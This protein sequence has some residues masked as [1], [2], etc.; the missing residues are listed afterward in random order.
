M[1]LSDCARCPGCTLYP[2]CLLPEETAAEDGVGT[3]Q[4]ICLPDP[5]ARPLAQEWYTPLSL[6]FSCLLLSLTPAEVA[7]ETLPVDTTLTPVT[8]TCG[9]GHLNFVLYKGLTGLCSSLGLF[10]HIC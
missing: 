7:V 4:L 8:K 10:S 1:E 2:A 3:R 6:T 9:C 5:P